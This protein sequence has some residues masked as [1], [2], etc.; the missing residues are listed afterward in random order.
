MKFKLDAG[1]QPALKRP[2][3]PRPVDRSRAGKGPGAGKKRDF[4]GIPS[5]F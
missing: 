3:T 1:P 4:V 2:P 5:A